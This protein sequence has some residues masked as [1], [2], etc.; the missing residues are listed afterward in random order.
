MN[1]IDSNHFSQKPLKNS[2][3]DEASLMENKQMEVSVFPTELLPHELPNKLNDPNIDGFL[4]GFTIVDN[5]GI[6]CDDKEV[7]EKQSGIIADVVK[8]LTTN[9]VKGLGITSLSLPIKVFEPKTQ[10]ERDIEWWAFAPQFLKKAGLSLDPIESL[11]QVTKFVLSALFLSTE[12]MKPFNPYLGE[13][14]QGVFDDGSQVYLEHTCHTPCISHYYLSDIDK[15]Y[16]YSGFF[17]LATEGALKMVLNNQLIVLNKGKAKAYLK[18]TNREVLIQCPS[19][20]I[21]GL[22]YGQRVVSWR[23]MLKIED[24]SNNLIVL[25]YFNKAISEL[26]DKR[27][28]DFIGG[29]YSHDFSK[30]KHKKHHNDNTHD[31]FEEKI[32]KKPEDKYRIVSIEGS[33]LEKLY[34]NNKADYDFR[35]NSPN[36]FYPYFPKSSNNDFSTYS[37]TE[38][39]ILPSDSRYREDLIWLKRALLN[40]E[41][42]NDYSLFSGKWKL[43]LEAQQRIDREKRK[44]IKKEEKKEKKGL[45]GAIHSMF[46]KK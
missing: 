1:N 25:V 39:I 28:H 19:I 31:F 16:T 36:K 43:I 21:G 11:K 37:N 46:K 24:H 41:N 32:K 15:T 42:Y 30:D 40:K 8:Q 20:A 14:Y 6:R 27:V 4:K 9:M 22:V 23:N 13:T 34:F 18:A 5:E 29:I 38:H 3:A 12:Q 17:E 7:V 45:F 2:F 33:Y 26:K 10:L 35:E 44:E